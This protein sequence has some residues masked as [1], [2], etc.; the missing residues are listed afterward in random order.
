MYLYFKEG[1]FD[2]TKIS[3]VQVADWTNA[4]NFYYRLNFDKYGFL[5]Y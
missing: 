5:G 1:N 3:L 4:L 2:D